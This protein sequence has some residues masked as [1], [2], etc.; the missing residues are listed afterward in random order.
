MLS[1]I[2]NERTLPYIATLAALGAWWVSWREA[3]RNNRVIVK[4]RKFGSHFTGTATSRVY[5]LEVWIVNRG[6]QMQDIGMALVF[7][8]R[9][10]SGTCSVPIPLSNQSKSVGL[11]FARGTT[12]KFLLSTASCDLCRLLGI[13]RDFHEQ[14]PAIHVYSSCF[15]ACS[16]PVYSRW[17]GLKKLWNRLS[18]R[19]SFQRRVGE[20]H[21]GKGVFKT[22]QLPRFVIR[23]EKLRFFLDGIAKS[24]VERASA[25]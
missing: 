15:L 9:G 17:D 6:M 10:K 16:F 8:G 24:A 1:E 3:R 5:E 14:R 2:F 20:G 4:L 25:S 19:L 21:E 23:S 7:A 22:Y 13:L 18:F 12:A 11:T